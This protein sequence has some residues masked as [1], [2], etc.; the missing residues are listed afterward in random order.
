MHRHRGVFASLLTEWLLASIADGSRPLVAFQ[1][2]HSAH[3][4]RFEILR[5]EAVFRSSCRPRERRLLPGAEG[6]PSSGRQDIARAGL[7]GLKIESRELGQHS[8]GPRAI[9]GLRSRVHRGGMLPVYGLL[10]QYVSLRDSAD[11]NG[12][13]LFYVIGAAVR[14]VVFAVA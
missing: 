7:A 12:A 13:A 3:S 2:L 11:V 5:G 1:L 6:S 9:K 14:C 10:Q 4:A 8:T